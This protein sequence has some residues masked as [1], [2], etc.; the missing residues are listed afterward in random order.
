[1]DAMDM[2]DE[3]AR[4]LADAVDA[5]LPG[6]V[7]RSVATVMARVGRPVEEDVLDDARE[8]GRRAA[9]EVGPV[10]RSLLGTDIDRQGSTPLTLLRD[11]VRY[12]TEVLERAGVEPPAPR[13]GTRER[14]FPGDVY[15]L[16]P[17]TFADVDPD[18]AAPGLAWGAAKAYEHLR[19]HKPPHDRPSSEPEGG[20][21]W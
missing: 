10:M 6:W 14:L 20:A 17:A 21:G 7:E 15:D 8:A 2:I 5:V 11:A 1:M 9:E 4:A 12:P 13:D 3:H 16:A 18:L 19:R